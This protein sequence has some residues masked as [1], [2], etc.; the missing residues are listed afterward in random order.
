MTKENKE[1]KIKASIE[2]Y[3]KDKKLSEISKVT[4]VSTKT[5]RK[6]LRDEGVWKEN[7]SSKSTKEE[8]LQEVIHLY[9]DGKNPS[10]I[11]TQFKVHRDTIINW[12]KSEGVYETMAQKADNNLQEYKLKT[13]DRSELVGLLRSGELSQE[14]TNLVVQRILEYEI[15]DTIEG[16]ERMQKVNKYKKLVETMSLL[17]GKDSNNQSHGRLTLNLELNKK[18]WRGPT[19]EAEPT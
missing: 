16:D 19:I 4:G 9:K 17:R 14:E 15:A 18:N 3:Q 6:W 1:S 12:L 10:Y 13:S 2:L 7:K 8:R 5:I 11:A